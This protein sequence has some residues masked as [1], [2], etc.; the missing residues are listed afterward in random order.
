M[1]AGDILPHIFLIHLD[2]MDNL[3][4]NYHNNNS[5]GVFL[6]RGM[7]VFSTQVALVSY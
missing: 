2:Y 5:P 7:V 6:F 4:Y 1:T 3:E